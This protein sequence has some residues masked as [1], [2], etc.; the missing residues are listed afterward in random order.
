M[1]SASAESQAVRRA[2]FILALLAVPAFAL[3]AL[4]MGKEAGW[5]FQNYHWYDPYSLLAGR[6]SFDVSVG[7]HASYYNPFLDVPLY[8]LG[9][10]FPAWVTGVWLGA[11]AGLGARYEDGRWGPSIFATG[12]SRG[13]DSLGAHFFALGLTPMLTR[14]SA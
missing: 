5:D 10:H 6:L 8:W 13:T 7:H 2:G 4:A 3:L 9:A 14:P 1:R 12:A 11:E